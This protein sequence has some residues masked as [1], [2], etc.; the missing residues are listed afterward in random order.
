MPPALD[1]EGPDGI[2]INAIGSI[3]PDQRGSLGTVRRARIV[4]D[5]RE[6]ALEEAGDLLTSIAAGLEIKIRDA[7]HD[8]SGVMHQPLGV[9]VGNGPV[10][11]S[12]DRCSRP[13]ALDVLGRVRADLQL[14]ARVALRFMRGDQFGHA[15]GCLLGNRS[16]QREVIAPAAAQK[17]ADWQSCGLSENIPA[18]DVDRGFHVGVALCAA[19]ILRL[20][21]LRRVGSS[22]RSWR[23]ISPMPVHAPS[24]YAGRSV[25]AGRP[26][27]SPKS[28]RRCRSVQGC[29]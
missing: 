26:L 28:P 4:V 24:A 9:G 21:T 17:L 10:F 29:C 16:I 3:L 6:A 20:R 5:D 27:R 25:R 11:E 12:E 14:E 19:S 15:L 23:P 2:H 13:D 1:S 8:P 7:L 22:P 18:C